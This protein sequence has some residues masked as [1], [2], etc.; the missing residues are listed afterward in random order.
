MSTNSPDA[1]LTHLAALVAAYNDTD[2][3]VKELEARKKEIRAVIEEALGDKETGT[4]NGAPVVRWTYVKTSRL[5]QTL[6]K[7]LHPRAY[8]ECQTVTTARRFTPVRD[9]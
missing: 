5:D 7:E 4:V 9:A 3:Q 1:D 8:A 6:L 2:E